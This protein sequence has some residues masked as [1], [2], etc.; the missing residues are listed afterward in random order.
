MHKQHFHE[1][2]SIGGLEAWYPIHCR[3]HILIA[4][5]PRVEWNMQI[6]N[7]VGNYSEIADFIWF[8]WTGSDITKKTKKKQKHPN[9]F[10][11]MEKH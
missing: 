6:L 7:Q 5:F 11:T 2:P 4:L 9:L 3:S 8:S 1:V 10:D